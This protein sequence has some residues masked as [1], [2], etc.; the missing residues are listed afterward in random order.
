MD[1]RLARILAN[2]TGDENISNHNRFRK[3]RL[4]YGILLLSE[5]DINLFQKHFGF[6]KN[7]FHKTK[8]P[9]QQML[10]CFSYY[11]HPKRKTI[12]L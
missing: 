9:K 8:V 2:I 4:Q 11:Y 10:N 5:N 3:L 7:S 6:S 1:I 12:H